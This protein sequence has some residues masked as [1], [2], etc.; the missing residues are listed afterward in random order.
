MLF[1]RRYG[2]LGMVTLPLAFFGIFIFLY[3]FG[4][5]VFHIVRGVMSKAVEI[6]TVGLSF[7]LPNVDSFFFNTDFMSI[8][9]Y[10]FLGLGLVI[11]WNGVKLAEGRFRPSIGIFYFISLY[12]IV[13]P[14]WLTRALINLVFSRSTSWR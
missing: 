3:N 5:V 4:F 6:S 12:G 11:I 13:A 1:R 9:A 2:I 14:I 8:L 7:A 10:V